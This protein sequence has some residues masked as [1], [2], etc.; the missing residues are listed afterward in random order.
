M[1]KTYLL[2]TS[3]ADVQEWLAASLEPDARLLATDIDDAEQL[4]ALIDAESLR[5]VF[6]PFSREALSLQS[7]LVAKL[8]AARPFLRVIGMAEELDNEL[9]LTAMRAGVH[10]FLRIGSPSAE[11]QTCVVRLR[12]KS[13]RSGAGAGRL[14]TI[15]CARPGEGSATLAVH[16]A[17]ALRQ[18][19]GQEQEL[20]LL[21]LGIPPADTMLFLDMKPT[22]TFSDALHSVRRFDDTLIKSAFSAHRSGLRVLPMAEDALEHPSGTSLHDA[23]VLL[24]VLTGYFDGIV[25]NFGGLPHTDFMAQAVLRSERVLLLAE[26]SV[27]SI[28]AS[29]RLV[30]FLVENGEDPTRIGLVVDRHLSR[31]EPSAEKM[32]EILSVPLLATLSSN[33]MERFGAMNLGV[34]VLEHAPQCNYAKEVKAL[35]SMLWR[36]EAEAPSS[37]RGGWTARLARLLGRGG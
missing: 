2:L 19:I 4:L 16:L 8:V 37:A 28:N 14:I 1:R 23:L 18:I 17:L 12:D 27:A 20:L 13:V 6:V 36:G 3:R 15:L 30:Q 33:G 10:D 26:Q 21:D 11:V 32:A 9:I 22:Y 5:L 24:S 7:R 29:R 35:A 31:L 25:A 34:S